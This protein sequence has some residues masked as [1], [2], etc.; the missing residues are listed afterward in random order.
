MVSST[1]CLSVFCFTAIRSPLYEGRPQG[2]FLVFDCIISVHYHIVKCILI[3]FSSL[4]G[5]LDLMQGILLQHIVYN[6]PYRMTL[7]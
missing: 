7:I 1:P 5:K 6:M 2:Y 3:E 4:V